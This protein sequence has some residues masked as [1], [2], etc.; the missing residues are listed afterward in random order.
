MAETQSQAFDRAMLLY[1]QKRFELAET[2]L[3]E[4]LAQAPD[5]DEL[6][7]LGLVLSAQKRYEAAMAEA[8]AAIGLA[9]DLAFAHYA[10]AA[11]ADD[12]NDLVTAQAAILEALRLNPLSAPLYG[13]QASIMAQRYEWSESLATADLGLALD[14]E[15]LGC[16]VARLLALQQLNRL[17]EAEANLMTGLARHPNDP[18]IHALKGWLELEKS[19]PQPAID[20]FR[21][22]LRLDPLNDSAR[23]GMI[24]ALKARNPLYRLFL[25]YQLWLGKMPPQMRLAALAVPLMGMRFVRVMAR[26]PAMQPIAYT[27]AGLYL[28]FLFSSWFAV[29]ITNLI[30]RFDAYGRLLLSRDEQMGGLWVCGL[31]GGGVLTV[32]VGAGLG[33]GPITMLGGLAIMLAFPVSGIFRCAPGWPRRWMRRLTIALASLVAVTLLTALGLPQLVW[34]PAALTLLGFVGCCWAANGL[35]WVTPK[36]A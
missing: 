10:L 32:L 8:E 4:S 11:I 12:R 27:L 13:L 14:P 9:P 18:T 36:Q 3:R 33:I 22:G 2:T 24:L 19:Q 23:E 31:L 28:L 17:P 35:A 21:E 1:E 15:H 6:A 25:K 20:G 30:L 7:L 26:I 5:A 29:P 16:L 34:V